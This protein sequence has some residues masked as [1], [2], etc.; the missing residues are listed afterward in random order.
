M[1]TGTRAYVDHVDALAARGSS[2]GDTRAV[3]NRPKFSTTEEG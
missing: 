3:V 1:N 2:R